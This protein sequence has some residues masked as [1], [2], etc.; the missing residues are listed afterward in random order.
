VIYG[1]SPESAPGQFQKTSTGP[2]NINV[3]QIDAS[4]QVIV[5]GN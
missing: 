5:V 4:F 2:G 3:K 1:Y